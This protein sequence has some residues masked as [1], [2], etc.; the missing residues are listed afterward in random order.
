MSEHQETN[1]NH[2]PLRSTLAGDPEMSDLL[3]EFIEDMPARID[4]LRT[5]WDQMNA[6]EVRRIAHQLKGCAAGYGFE[7]MG[8][9]ARVLDTALKQADR[10]LA[11]VRQEFDTLIDLC[12]R[13]TTV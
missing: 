11:S 5:A 9:A 12:S 10:E 4:D 1:R 6:Q 3:K 2:T 13:A 8:E 7:P